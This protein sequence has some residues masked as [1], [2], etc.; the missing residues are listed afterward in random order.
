ME[1]K[2]KVTKITKME[3]LDNYGNT[4]FIVEFANGDKGFY[5]SKNPNQTKFVVGNVADYLIEEK[6]GQ[7]GTYY[8]ITAPQTD[9]KVFGKKSA[10]DPRYQLIGFSYAYAKDLVV[11]SKVNMPDFHKVAEDIFKNMIRFH[12]TIK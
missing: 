4:T 11:G 12:D 3:K 2:D 8:K 9:L 1:K 10:P 5:T 6:Q 7:K